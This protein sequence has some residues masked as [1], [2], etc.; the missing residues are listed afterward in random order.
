MFEPVADRRPDASRHWTAP[1]KFS[2]AASLLTV[3]CA[4]SHS[5]A[6]QACPVWPVAG[7]PC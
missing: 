3:R 2:P 5:G 7:C 1:T 4:M 6:L